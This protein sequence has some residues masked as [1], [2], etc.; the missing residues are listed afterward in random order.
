MSCI[1]AMYSGC[2]RCT[3]RLWY[4][5]YSCLAEHGS[6]MGR[7][8]QRDNLREMKKSAHQSTRIMPR[9]YPLLQ[10]YGRDMYIAEE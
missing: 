10:E 8:D 2:G 5:E 1:Q 4:N 6:G 3:E 7:E 9:L